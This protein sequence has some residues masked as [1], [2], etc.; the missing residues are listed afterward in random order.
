[1]EYLRIHLDPM[2]V[3]PASQKKRLVHLKIPP[4]GPKE[5]NIDR[6]HQVYPIFWGSKFQ[7]LVF[8]ANLKL[9]ELLSFLYDTDWTVPEAHLVALLMGGGKQ[10][11][12]PLGCGQFLQ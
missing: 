10:H 7:P 3:T 9:G 11:W 1:M 8:E 4:K 2:S 12:S 6:N 5:I